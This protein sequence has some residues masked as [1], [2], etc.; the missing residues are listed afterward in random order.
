VADETDLLVRVD[1]RIDS[2]QAALAY[3]THLGATALRKVSYQPGE[4]VLVIGL[5]VI[6]LCTVALASSM[7]A[8]VEAVA[9]SKQRLELARTIKAQRAWDAATLDPTTVFHGCGAD[10]IV[11]T[12]NTW[13]AY[14]TAVEAAAPSGRIALLGFPGRAQPEP[15]FNPL[16]AHWIYGKQLTI[17]GAGFAPRVECAPEEIRFN[18]RRSLE[19]ILARLADKRLD[20][21]PMISH[22]IPAASMRDAY[23]LAIA[24]DKSLTAAV[25]LW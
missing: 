4:S 2:A 8:S 25:F 9:N 6:G 14:R 20:F 18:L 1:P 16:D 21:A 24:H 10:V 12:A 11:L 5:G 22:R 7:G 19:D 13:E 15:S 17:A 23:E 3:L